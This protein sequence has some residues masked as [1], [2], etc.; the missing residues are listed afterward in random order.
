MPPL[1][2]LPVV[3]A[4]FAL[5]AWSQEKGT[6]R[7]VVRIARASSGAAG[8]ASGMPNPLAQYLESKIPGYSFQVT[9]LPTVEAMQDAFQ[10]GWNSRSSMRYAFPRGRSVTAP[11]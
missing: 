9:E 4:F 10:N 3:L 2:A 1:L 11:A 8:Q 7:P 5:H 6:E